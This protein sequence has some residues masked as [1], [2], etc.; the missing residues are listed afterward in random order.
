MLRNGN[1]SLPRARA[2]AA[3]DKAE[4]DRDAIDHP[5]ESLMTVEQEIFN[6]RK[7]SLMMNESVCSNNCGSTLR[8]HAASSQRCPAMRIV[9]LSALMVG[10]K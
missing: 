8:L 5:P 2:D 4:K 1:L 3:D 9:R 10:R 7:D 6:P